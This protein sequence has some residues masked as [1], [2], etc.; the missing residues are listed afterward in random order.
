MPLIMR[1]KSKTCVLVHENCH[2]A[3]VFHL[4]RFLAI[5]RRIMKKKIFSLKK[6]S[7]LKKKRFK[8]KDFYIFINFVSLA[9]FGYFVVMS[10]IE[11]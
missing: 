7:I 6:I 10:C 1:A 4:K 2:V 5:D 8:K 9:G 11:V 3:N